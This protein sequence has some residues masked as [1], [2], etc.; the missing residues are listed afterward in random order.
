MD[1][2]SRV[3]LGRSIDEI[4]SA[5]AREYALLATLLSYSPD[6]QLLSALAGLPGD[7]SPIGLA[8]TALA[9]KAQRLPKKVY[10][11]SFLRCS[12]G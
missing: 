8:H 6:V 12:P 11:A 3:L 10:R 4:D 1:S 9:K 7:T 2:A 5:R